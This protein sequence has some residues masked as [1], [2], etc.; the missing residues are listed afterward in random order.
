VK[1]RIASTTLLATICVVG[2]L[3]TLTA[4]ISAQDFT[5]ASGATCS[6][7]CV[8][9][10]HNDNAR[11]GVNSSETSL[12][13]SNVSGSSFVLLKN[14]EMLDGL[15]YAQP[16]YLSGITM[17]SGSGC[18]GVKNIVIV[19]TENN[20]IYAFDV[21]T[22]SSTLYQQCWKAQLNASGE[23][24]IPFTDLIGSVTECNNLIPQEGITGTPA[25]DL[26]VTPPA[27]Y[28]VSAVKTSTTAWD[29]KLSI[30]KADGGTVISSKVRYLTAQIQGQSGGLN[31]SP[32][33]QNQRPGLALFRPSTGNKVNLYVGFGSHCD[34]TPFQGYVAGFQFVYSPATWNNLGVFNTEAGGGID[35]GVWMGGGAPALDSNGNVYVATGNGDW[36]GSGTGGV[37]TNLGESVV[38]LAQSGSSLTAVDYYTPNSWMALNSGSGTNSVC[39]TYGGTSCPNGYSVSLATNDYDLGGGGVTLMN[40]KGSGYTSL[41]GTNAEL[42]A[43]GK[44][45]VAYG[46]CYNPSA[47]SMVMGGLDSCGYT[48]TTG[49]NGCSGSMNLA[50]VAAK[51]ACTQSGTGSIAQCFNGM[52]NPNGVDNGNRG[53]PA[54]WAGTAS[55]PENYLYVA[56]IAD[57]IK[58]YTLTTSGSFNILAATNST[59][60]SSYGYPG[61]SP[62]LSWSGTD[63]TTGLV[64]AIDTN[65]N[66]GKYNRQT[67]VSTAAGAATLYGYT[68]IPSS[69]LLTNDVDSSTLALL[70]GMTHYGPGAVKFVV[71]TIA[72]GLVFVAGGAANPN[73]YK[74]GKDTSNG[75]NCT[76][77]ASGGSCLGALYIYGLH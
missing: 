17:A 77:S 47:S 53:N 24:A 39:L 46:V 65:G 55:I 8:T 12:K 29:F 74:P 30:V 7:G 26:G 37:P 58:A 49:T 36:N 66:Y 35:A 72:G 33:Q 21:T 52:A 40:P 34:S 63:G 54:F 44:E 31:F 22:G 38:Q 2:L 9:T 48:F 59:T 27:I 6:S 16:L 45:G 68:A 67:G 62:S 61:A 13:P 28:A 51:T 1:P 71:P 69:S 4:S 10:H 14:I 60:P 15:V 43:A 3:W 50:N 73:Y 18:P 19:A 64:W 41:C 70:P 42:V 25:I 23:N 32:L 11:D 75:A 5:Q 56:G 20:S 76:P 57:T